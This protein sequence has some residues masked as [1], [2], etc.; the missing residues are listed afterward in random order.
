M[1]R[2]RTENTSVILHRKDKFG[3]TLCVGGYLFFMS[4]C[5][6]VM[7]SDICKPSLLVVMHL[8]GLVALWFF[9]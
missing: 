5:M 2:H 9:K 6:C 8:S 1:E 4:E 7:R 3:D